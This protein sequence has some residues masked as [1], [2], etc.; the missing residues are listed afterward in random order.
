MCEGVA[1]VNH[2]VDMKACRCTDLPAR[3][4]RAYPD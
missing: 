2:A 1:V 4:A 3:Y